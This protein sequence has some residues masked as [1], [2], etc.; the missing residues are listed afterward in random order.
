MQAVNNILASWCLFN[1]P[2]K[3][4]ELISQSIKLK[5]KN[6]LVVW[7]IA[8]KEEAKNVMFWSKKRHIKGQKHIAS[9]DFPKHLRKSDFSENSKVYNGRFLWNGLHESYCYISKRRWGVQ[10]PEVC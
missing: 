7:S 1:E 6:K 10:Y 3:T 9:M 2:I 4:D 8:M 5:T